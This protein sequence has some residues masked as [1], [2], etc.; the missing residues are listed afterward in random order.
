[1]NLFDK[2]NEAEAPTLDALDKMDYVT[3]IKTLGANANDPKL[4]A[5]IAA[6]M[7]DGNKE[8]DAFVF[9]NPKPIAV[10]GCF[11]TQNEVV[12]GKSL[13]FPL[14]SENEIGRAHV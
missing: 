7:E 3:F 4:K 2:L 12:M 11:P 1:M 14:E 13:A 8:D 9:S 6:G 10:R 5:A